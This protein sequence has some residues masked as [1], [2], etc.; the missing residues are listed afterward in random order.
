VSLSSAR[1]AGEATGRS[2][3]A[4][5]PDVEGLRAIAVSL[6]VLFHAGVPFLSGGFVGVDVFF[7]LSGFLITGILM[8]E[9]LA[10]ARTSFREFYARRARRILP[11]ATLVLIVTVLASYRLLGFVRADDVAVDAQWTALFAA[12]IWFGIEN[13]QY[14]NILTKPSPLQH[15]WSLGVEE[16]FYL[17]WPLVFALAA[18]VARS[19]NLRGRLTVVLVAI[20]VASFVWSI[21]QT[22]Q[23]AVWG[24]F[25]PLT[26]AWELGAG[27]LLALVIPMVAA[28]RWRLPPAG[29]A[30]ISWAGIA[31]IAAGAILFTTDTP[32]PGAAAI[33]PVASTVAVVAAGSLVPGVG[34]GRVLR[35]APFQWLG[36]RSYSTYLWHWPL[37]TIAAQRYGSTLP[38]PLTLVLIVAT[39]VLAAL[40][41][42][43]LEDPVRRSSRLHARPALSLAVGAALVA[44]GFLVATIPLVAGDV[45]L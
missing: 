26:R 32:F 38:W 36:R 27:A 37:L 23:D 34:A 9:R 1:P 6:V 11:A 30:A 41:F 42:R 12:N 39:V 14:E 10:S 15:Y 21:I 45:G 3:D 28:R 20:T 7:V 43:F 16:Q 44:A 25:S 18:G 5:R 33:V 13:T 19:A 35:L 22:E 17:V 24:F 40:T 29:G 31:G 4:F 2:R 8:R